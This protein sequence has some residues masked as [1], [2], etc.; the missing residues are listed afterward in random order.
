MARKGENIRKRK[1]GRW[2]G[3]YKSGIKPDGKSKYTSV[4]GKSY[5]EVK[6]KLTEIKRG[7]ACF[8]CSPY[9]EKRFS[10]VLILWLKSNKIKLK[11]STENKYKYMIEKHIKPQLGGRWISTV[12]APIINDFLLEKKNHGRLDGKGGLAASY[13]KT[14]AIIIESAIKFAAAE[15]FCRPLKNQITK[16]L[17]IKKEIQI[18]SISMQKHFEHSVMDDIDETVTGIYIAL[19]AG[20]R[21]GEICALSWDDIDFNSQ[22]IHVRHTVSRVEQSNSDNSKSSILIIDT[23]KTRTSIRE[24]PISKS[25]LHI[26]MHMKESSTSEYVISTHSGFLSP[27]TFDYRYKC[28]LRRLGMPAVNFHTF[29]HTFATRCIEVGMDIKS[30]SKILGHANVSITLNTYVHPSMDIIR[31][32]LE[33]L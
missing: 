21:I 17:T 1:D 3:R 24:I 10:D 16:P 29:R 14:M 12:T 6:N 11:G 26:L 30:L 4:Y 23:P 13:V 8:N 19:Y 7:L 31:G 32:Q 18:L 33:R 28:V 9:I 22:I 5:T 25:L 27:R 20:L 2:E 15:G